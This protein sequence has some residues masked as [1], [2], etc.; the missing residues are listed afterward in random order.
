MRFWGIVALAILAGCG[1]AETVS[2]APP[3]AQEA[4]PDSCNAESYADLVGGPLDAF[5]QSGISDPVR[6]IPPG[7]I[8]TTE[9]NPLRLNVDLNGRSQIVRFWC[10]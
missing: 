7:G 1:P 8:V 5:D 4:G 9:Y 10:G 3:R 2:G 6:I